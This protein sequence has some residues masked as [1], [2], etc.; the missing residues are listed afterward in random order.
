MKKLIFFLGSFGI[1]LG[2]L[3]QNFQQNQ[4]LN[5]N[6]LNITNAIAYT[7]NISY[8]GF[9]TT[10]AANQVYTNNTYYG[11]PTNLVQVTDVQAA[12][13]NLSVFVLTTNGIGGFGASGFY[14][15]DPIALFRDIAWNSD[16]DGVGVTNATFAVWG[17]SNGSASGN[18][19]IRLDPI[20][21]GTLSA[22]TGPLGG[23]GLSGTPLVLDTAAGSGHEVVLTI[24]LPSSAYFT[25]STNILCGPNIKGWHVNGITNNSIVGVV[26]LQGLAG[27]DYVP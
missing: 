4:F 22:G 6:T 11:N 18:L 16:R 1:T 24:N 10:N 19:V 9:V 20:L 17:F 21:A 15:N 13:T 23:Y 25:W 2:V 12:G 7:N 14:T 3:G 27:P 5:I 8:Y 26:Y